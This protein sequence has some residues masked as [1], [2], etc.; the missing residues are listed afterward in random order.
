LVLITLIGFGL[1]AAILRSGRHLSSRRHT[2]RA[3]KA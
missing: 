3:V 2:S 1:G